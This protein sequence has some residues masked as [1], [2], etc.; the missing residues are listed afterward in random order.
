MDATAKPVGPFEFLAGGGEMGQRIRAFDWA[1]TPLGPPEGWPQSL[2]SA[3]SML[4]PSKAQ[5]VFFWGRDLITLYNDA[6]RPVFGAKHPRVLG[7]PARES[8]SELWVTGLKELFEGVL[9]TGEAYWASD[10]P[11]YIER[12]GY[13]EETFF[14]VSYDPVRDETGRV[15]GVFCI[16]NET[17]ERVVSARRLKTLRELGVRTVSEAKSAEDACQS[18]AQILAAN[19]YDLPF[20][21]IYLLDADGKLARLAGATG[22]Q[23]D[24][25]DALRWVDMTESVGAAW[26]LR[27][28]MATGHAEVVADLSQP[29]WCAAA[30]RLARVPQDRCRSTHGSDGSGSTSRFPRGRGKPAPAAGRSVP[31]F[32]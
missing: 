29:A 20:T 7:L 4:L 12:F 16:V 19:K 26:P 27:N 31:R 28:V 14:D 25:P 13:P 17:T 8:W 32:F 10:R 11:F 6:Y 9:A 3:L 18:A 2:R 1:K 24:L 5:I 21:I 23:E 15:G 30:R 22:L